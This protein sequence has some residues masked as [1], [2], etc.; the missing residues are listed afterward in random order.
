[1]ARRKTSYSDTPHGH[2]YVSVYCDGNA[3]A[4][5]P[6]SH[7]GAPWRIA[8]FHINEDA[9]RAAGELY[10]SEGASAY[11]T[12][13][14]KNLTFDTATVTTRLVGDRPLA[15]AEAWHDPPGLRSRVRLECR[16]CGLVHVV[17]YERLSVALTMLYA[18]DIREVSLVGLAAIVRSR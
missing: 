14:G 2:P 12:A 6:P 9:S 4:D 15:A 13:E 3:T 11:T 7:H 18:A 1:M 5:G 8:T 16:T 10:W 17:R